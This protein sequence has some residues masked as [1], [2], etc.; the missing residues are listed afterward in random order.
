MVMLLEPGVGGLRI[1]PQLFAP[2]VHGQSWDLVTVGLGSN[3]AWRDSDAAEVA[4]RAAELCQLITNAMIKTL[5]LPPWKPL[6]D[7]KG[8]P[9]FFGYR[10]S[11]AADRLLHSPRSAASIATWSSDNRAW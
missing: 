8:P 6:E 2:A 11:S 1:E 3:H 4:Q 7:G 9:E 5:L 10:R